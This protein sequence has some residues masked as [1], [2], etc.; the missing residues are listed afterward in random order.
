MLAV[1]LAPLPAVAVTISG[2][3]LP[4]ASSGMVQVTGLPLPPQVQPAPEAPA[5]VAPAMFVL[6]LMFCAVFGPRLLTLM[7]N[8]TAL[9][10]GTGFGDAD[11]VT[12]R[13]AVAPMSTEMLP[14]AVQVPVATATEMPIGPESPAV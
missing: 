8:A 9:P 2:D 3:A 10:L 5:N 12:F 11:A 14:F 7:V 1:A 4:S 13:S 6:T